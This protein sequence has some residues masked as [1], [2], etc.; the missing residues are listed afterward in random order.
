MFA[1]LPV[2]CNPHCIAHASSKTARVATSMAKRE[3]EACRGSL[4]EVTMSVARADASAETVS[5]ADSSGAKLRAV[6]KTMCACRTRRMA[7]SVVAEKIPMSPVYMH[8]PYC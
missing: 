6:T 4:L 1:S 8:T 3:L 2:L 5:K 7:T